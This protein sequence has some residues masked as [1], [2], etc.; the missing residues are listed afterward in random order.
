MLAV[1]AAVMWVAAF[2][3]FSPTVIGGWAIVVIGIAGTIYGARAHGRQ[4]TGEVWQATA[5]GY[6]E[7]AQLAHAR[8]ERLQ[9]EQ[10]EERARVD[11]ERTEERVRLEAE[12]DEQRA[13]KHEALSTVAALTA[14]TDLTVVMQTLKSILDT[15]ASQT[16]LLGKLV[17]RVEALSVEAAGR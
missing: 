13:L 2:S 3:V 5:L 15:Q 17:D 12:R 9:Y 14:K 6:K 8:A 4:R 7:E 10:R 1:A 11:A 16:E